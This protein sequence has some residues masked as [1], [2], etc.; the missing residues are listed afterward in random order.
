L[1][2]AERRRRRLLLLLLQKRLLLLLLSSFRSAPPHSADPSP[3]TAAAD[4]STGGRVAAVNA[5]AWAAWAALD[6]DEES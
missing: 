3:A 5:A 4:L 1:F 6:L 2:G